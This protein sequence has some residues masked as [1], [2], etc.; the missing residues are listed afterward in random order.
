MIQENLEFW[1]CIL[2]IGL[3]SYFCTNTTFVLKKPFPCL[4]CWGQIQG[5]CYWGVHLAFCCGWFGV[6]TLCTE[7]LG[8]QYNVSWLLYNFNSSF[9]QRKKVVAGGRKVSDGQS[10]E[11][12]FRL[13][14][15]QGGLI[16]KC[17]YLEPF[18]TVVQTQLSA[19]LWSFPLWQVRKF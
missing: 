15:K 5:H 11:E 18:T 2:L 6:C 9:S 13:R 10:L 3:F 7:K 17:F 12:E 4:W 1:V 16:T 19:Y 8:R 14:V